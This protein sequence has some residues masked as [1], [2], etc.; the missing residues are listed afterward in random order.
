MKKNEQI[1][2]FVGRI[3]DNRSLS[4][5][6]RAECIYIII[7]SLSREKYMYIYTQK[8]RRELQYIFKASAVVVYVYTE[9]APRLSD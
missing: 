7:Y 4:N 9:F 3:I 1:A 6:T 2:A 8:S 5:Q